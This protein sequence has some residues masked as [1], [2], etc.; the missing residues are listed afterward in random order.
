MEI[1]K[2]AL[3][4]RN[5]YDIVILDLTIPGGM[6]GKEIVKRMKE[7]DPKVKAI[8]SSGYSDDE[9]MSRPK[10]FGFDASLA[11]PYAI[12]ALSKILQELSSK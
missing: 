12:E 6:G 5:R 11:K 8:A 1:F 7:F 3:P 2:N 4:S 9:I 10:E